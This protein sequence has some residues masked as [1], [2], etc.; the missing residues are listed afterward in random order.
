MYSY[1]LC[2]D[3]EKRSVCKYNDKIE[4]IKKELDDLNSPQIKTK[5]SIE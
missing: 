2:Y 3:C 4:D 5:I 1:L